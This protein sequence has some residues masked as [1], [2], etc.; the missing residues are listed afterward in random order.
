MSLPDDNSPVD[1]PQSIGRDP[2]AL[3]DG[4]PARDWSAL[5]DYITNNDTPEAHASTE[6]RLKNDPAFAEFARPIIKLWSIPL[7]TSD[8]RDL[9]AGWAEIQRKA[10]AL[11][12]A[13]S[14]LH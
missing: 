3:I 13:R 14:K 9:D 12:K 1:N 10:A 6:A 5:V 8:T 7:N 11:Q 2:D 4:V